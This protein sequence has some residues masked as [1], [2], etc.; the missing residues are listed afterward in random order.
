MIDKYKDYIKQETLSDELIK[1]DNLKTS[2]ML[3]DIEC[4]I[5]TKKV[6]S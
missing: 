3:N 6:S 1:K 5:E 4:F 2:Y